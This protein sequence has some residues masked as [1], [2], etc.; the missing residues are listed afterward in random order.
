MRP[1]SER[2]G[3]GESEQGRELGRKM[4]NT[5][6]HCTSRLSVGWT[7]RRSRSPAACALRR[8]ADQLL[9]QVRL[10]AQQLPALRGRHR[11]RVVADCLQA[12][13][14]ERFRAVV[15]RDQQPA[16]GLAVRCRYA[17]DR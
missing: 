1:G 12:V 17:L 16:G 10:R 15:V 5:L 4:I 2:G 7:C 9:Q 13:L 8:R 3:E 14:L 11:R 6:T